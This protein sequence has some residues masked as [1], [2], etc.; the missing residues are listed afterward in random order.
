MPRKSKKPKKNTKAEKESI[1]WTTSETRGFLIFS[2]AI[3]LLLSLMSFAIAPD[4]KNL[5][6]LMGHTLGWALHAL[7]GLSSYGLVLYLGWI[8]WRLLFCKSL[9]FLWLKHLYVAT[10]IVSLSMLLTLIES[11]ASHLAQG[12]GHTF[13]P[14]LWAL[15]MRYH[16]GGA[17]F[18]YLYR[19][20]PSFNLNHMFN[21]VGVALIFSSTLIASLLFLFKIRLVSL[22]Q[23]LLTSIKQGIEQRRTLTVPLP[24][25]TPD[26]ASKKENKK[27]EESKK[28]SSNA[29][30]KPE[31]DFLRFVKLRIPTAHF[32]EG[33]VKTSSPLAP[34]PDLLA[35]RPEK[36]LK[37]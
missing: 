34:S 23:A 37:E 13:Y 24:P 5:L 21:T 9:H 30:D 4:S 33:V 16:L 25:S 26:Q 10:T 28:A 1:P 14:G 15:N 7:M 29:E 12:I 19:D 36:N 31:S 17:P 8:G 18:F 11:D 27:E 20:L 22:C 2:F 6:G 32:Q 3:V 35:I